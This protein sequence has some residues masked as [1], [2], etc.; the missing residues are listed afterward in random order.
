MMKVKFKA[1]AMM[2]T[3]IFC[4]A[5]AQLKTPL[6]T[7]LEHSDVEAAGV[8][9]YIKDV[10]NDSVLVDHNSKTN[11]IPASVTKVV[12]TA[13]A[14]EILSDTFRF[15][16][17]VLY[18]GSLSADSVLRGNLYV[19]GGGDPSLESEYAKGRSFLKGTVEA[20]KKLGIKKINGAV[21][22]DASLYAQGGAP[23]QW[24]VEDIGTYYAPVP[25][26]LS[27]C[28]NVFNLVYKGSAGASPQLVS[29][30]PPT[31]LLNI[32]NDMNSGGDTWW[33]AYCKPY[34]WDVQLRGNLPVGKN[35]GIR[36]EIPEP[37]LLVA[38]SLRAMLEKSGVKVALPSKT[39]RWDTIK[40]PEGARLVFAHQSDMLKNLIKKTNYRSINLYAENI[41]LRLALQKA[42]VATFQTAS[43][44][45]AQFWKSKG[46]NVKHTYQADGS[47][48]S[49][50]NAIS[51]KFMVD[52]LTY[53]RRGSVYSQQFTESL[54][55]AGVNGTVKSLFANTPL[56][57]KVYAKSGSMERVQ[58]YCGYVFHNN[59]VYAFSVMLNNFDG[60]RYALR[61]RLA[62]LFNEIFK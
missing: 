26:A 37:E 10:M 29:V 32:Q 36:I 39:T 3:M 57:G 1:V 48:L 25:S 31:S 28:D 61:Q 58:N 34:S 20:V 21:I 54:P 41:F 38:D 12:T 56:A 7:F 40:V 19:V 17:K 11:L 9:I 52:V 6:Q 2:A 51:S 23:I 15:E 62:T 22:A 49:M 55:Q 60:G 44:V 43:D 50:K 8:S 33:R 4:S 59:R 35:S 46:L 13:A 30:Y 14:L 5:S 53:M 27:F 42:E 47:G 45:V 18:D 24:L 16:T